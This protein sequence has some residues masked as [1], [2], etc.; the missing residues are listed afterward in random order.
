MQL[1]MDQVPAGER[2]WLE[3]HSGC[4]PNACCYTSFTP[5]LLEGHR[6]PQSAPCQWPAQQNHG[7]AGETRPQKALPWHRHLTQAHPATLADTTPFLSCCS[8]LLLPETVGARGQASHRRGC[9][10]GTH[11]KA[12]MVASWVKTAVLDSP[13]L[14]QDSRVGAGSRCLRQNSAGDRPGSETPSGRS[15]LEETKRQGVCPSM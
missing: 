12:A 4:C 8:P 13:G 1:P 14:A 3:T 11:G 15:A 9:G 10:A 2:C 7:A 5:H 6:A